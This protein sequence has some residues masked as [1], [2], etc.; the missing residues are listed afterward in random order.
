MGAVGDIITKYIVL[1]FL[2][3]V[4]LSSMVWTFSSSDPL[5]NEKY[6][7]K[8]L[9]LSMNLLHMLLFVWMLISVLYAFRKVLYEKTRA[10]IR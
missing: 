5:T 8:R 2:I 1:V 10:N 9:Q 7:D 6:N 3:L 4:T